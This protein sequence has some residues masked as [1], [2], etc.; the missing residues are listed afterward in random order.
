MARWQDL[1][2]STWRSTV[3]GQPGKNKFNSDLENDQTVMLH[4]A[5]LFARKSF[6]SKIVNYFFDN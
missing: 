4:A 6:L 1:D 2:R 5:D 3:R